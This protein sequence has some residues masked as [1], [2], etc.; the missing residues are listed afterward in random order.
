MLTVE[1][2][3][4]F[5]LE[6]RTSKKKRMAREGLRYFEGE[7]DIK[8]YRVFYYNK[9]GK[10]IEDK[11]SA[12]GR[13][14]SGFF[15]ENVQQKTQFTLSAEGKLIRS[16]IPELQEQLDLRFDDEFDSE[17]SDVLDYG[18]AEGF[19]YFYRYADKDL[20]SKFK[21]AEGLHVIEVESKYASDN[22]DH[23]IYYYLE[24]VKTIGKGTEYIT[25]IQDWDKQFTYFYIE[26]NNDIKI[27]KSVELNPRP[28]IIYNQNGKKYFETFGSIPFYR[29][30]N[31]KREISDLKPIKEYIDS[32]DIINYGLFDNILSLSE[33]YFCVKGFQGDDLDE[34]ITTLKTKHHIGVPEEGDLAVH[35]VDIPYEARKTKMDLDKEN[36]YQFGMSFNPTQ[37][38]DGNVTNVVIKSR[39][40]LLDIKCSHCAKMLKKTLKQM[41]SDV[42]DEINQANNTEYTLK[43]VWFNLDDR[44]VITNE[45]DN[46][47]IEQLKA[48]TEQLKINTLL[49]I[50][51]LFDNETLMQ[52]ICEI[53]D[54]DY[55]LI[56]GKLPK[57]EE[58]ESL[59]NAEKILNKQIEGDT[60]VKKDE[61]PE[62]KLDKAPAE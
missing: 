58:E 54:I 5:I 8:Q 16:D 18:S 33:G 38:G 12:G 48:Q 22:Q 31:N 40:G 47:Q 50:Q 30:S 26:E 55:E 1:E 51:T 52:N 53:L 13:A 62:D 17:V 61:K 43:D 2:I 27:D 45:L 4:Q 46:A 37:V 42:L 29:Y 21:F 49:N 11:R 23:I 39:Y 35:T 28:H 14:A 19:S 15:P 57:P 9:D 34:L 44:E 36:I 20:I 60:T 7:N 56:K 59:N 6:D 25:K 3:K 24:K 32:Y 10:L 41:V